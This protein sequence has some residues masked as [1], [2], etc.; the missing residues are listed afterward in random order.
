MKSEF[1]MM[2]EN[3]LK[4]TY[5]NLEISK[6]QLKMARAELEVLNSFHEKGN[7]LEEELNITVDIIERVRNT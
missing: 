4:Q 7:I 6:H 2:K 5:E 1:E 3:I